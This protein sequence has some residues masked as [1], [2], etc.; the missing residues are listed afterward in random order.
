ML[1]RY[2]IGFVV[3]IGLV[4][5]LIYLVFHGG[6]KPKVPMTHK[7]LDSYSV[8]DAQAI[9]TIDGP[10]NANQNHQGVKIIVSRDNVTF[11]QLQGYQGS[12]TNMQNFTNNVDAYSNFLV[13]IAR[14]GFT[15]GNNN[16]GLKDERGYCPLGD[17]Y[18]F[19]L[20][21]DG[22]ELERY[23]TT[24]CGS[25]KSFLGNAQLT[26]TLFQNQVPNYDDLTQNITL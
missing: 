4:I 3:T 1:N 6:S 19:E 7:T 16:A 11:E 13:A 24:S 10:I 8:T 15:L 20:Q 17:R 21:Q 12:V 26:L 9:M 2:F 5:L 18:N 25:P 14:A 23:W 22:Q